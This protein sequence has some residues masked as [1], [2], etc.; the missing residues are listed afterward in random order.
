[1]NERKDDDAPR[2]EERE[3]GP[4]V[5]RNITRMR[6]ED[7]AEIETKPVMVHRLV[8]AFTFPSLSRADPGLHAS[9]AMTSKGASHDRAERICWDS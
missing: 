2:I 5:A 3:D 4:F 9:I 1:M 6:G 7:G 8:N